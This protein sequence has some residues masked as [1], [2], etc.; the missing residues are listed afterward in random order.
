MK[1]TT[2]D[3]E[4][5]RQLVK[6]HSGIDLGLD[7]A[8]LAEAR[9]AGIAR[10]Q[11]LGS[12]SE[13]VAQLRTL[14]SSSLLMREVGEAMLIAETSFF[15]DIH[16]FDM[17][18]L[19]VLPELIIRH[20][21]R[22]RLRIWCAACSSGQEPYS[23]AMLIREH[24]PQLAGWDIKIIATDISHT[25][26]ERA[27]EGRF[28]QMEVGRG[29]PAPLL[30]RYFSRK[31]LNWYAND[32][33]RRMVTF[34]YMNLSNPAGKQREMDVVFLRNVLI[35]FDAPLKKA[36]LQR[37]RQSMHADGYLFLGSSETTV[38]L[39]TRFKPVRMHNSLCYRLHAST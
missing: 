6:N 37:V 16:P 30:V 22:R 13:L 31:G 39:D 32:E 4:F 34:E 5:I 33:I 38:Y 1:L 2:E 35:Y 7:K 21:G 28:N 27:R 24:F 18:R 15:R 36:I 29:L 3:F 19:T 14:S 26:L 23:I 25:I 17:L 9:L 11:R 12:L 8:Y 20:A 10:M